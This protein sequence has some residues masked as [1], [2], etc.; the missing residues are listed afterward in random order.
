ME[1]GKFMHN[2][3]FKLI[4]QVSL[5]FFTNHNYYACSCGKEDDDYDIGGGERYKII[6]YNKTKP[7]DIKQDDE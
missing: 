4:K 1:W 3:K 2:H 5:P 7:S 6:G